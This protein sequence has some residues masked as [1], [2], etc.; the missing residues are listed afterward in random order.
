MVESI[1]AR[2]RATE[3]HFVSL[4]V[5]VAGNL[6]CVERVIGRGGEIAEPMAPSLFFNLLRVTLP[7]TEFKMPAA[8]LMDC[9]V[10]VALIRFTKRL[11]L[12]AAFN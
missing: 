2:F 7:L 3:V 12:E 4:A 10:A 6:N 1:L 9:S 11:I 5:S 8:L